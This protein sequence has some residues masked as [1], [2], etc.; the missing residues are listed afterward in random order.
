[1]L[2]LH[3]YYRSSAAFFCRIAFNLKGVAYETAF[4]H[5]VKDGGRSMRQPIAR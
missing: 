4:V 3:S 5:L 1:M 2:K